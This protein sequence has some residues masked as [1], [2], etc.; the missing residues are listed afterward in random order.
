MQQKQMFIDTTCSNP[1][2]APQYTTCS[3]PR[4][5]PQCTTCSTSGMSTPIPN[6]TVAKTIR[7]TLSFLEI[8]LIHGPCST[9]QL[10]CET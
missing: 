7:K 3:N 4:G 10:I 2:G 8:P 6:A 5:A 9:E 1:R